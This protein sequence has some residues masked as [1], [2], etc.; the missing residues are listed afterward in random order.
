VRDETQKAK[1]PMVTKILVVE[2]EPAIQELIAFNLDK[3]GYSVL[4][5]GDAETAEQMINAAIPALLI[6]D[7]MLPGKSGVTLIRGLRMRPATRHLPIIM[8][9]ARATEQDVVM[10]LESGADDYIKKPFS[11]REM[12]ARVRVVLRR[13]APQTEVEIIAVGSLTL[14]LA[15]R[16]V[17]VCGANVGM[18][19]TEFRLLHFFISHPERVHSRNSL[20]DKVWGADTSINERTVDAHVGRLRSTLEAAGYQINIETIRGVGYCFSASDIPS[21]SV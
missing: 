3:A 17:T 18:T 6:V 19:P 20:I 4:R 8:M 5:A 1:H 2:D 9:T 15:K 7:W 11:P 21:M 14:D 10:A 16:R 13:Y 12:L